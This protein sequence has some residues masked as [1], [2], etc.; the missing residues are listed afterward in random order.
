VLLCT[1][2]REGFPN[3]FIEARSHGVL[4]VSTHDHDGTIARLGWGQW[5]P[6]A[7]RLAPALQAILD[8]WEAWTP[9]PPQRRYKHYLRNHT[10]DLVTE[11]FE[12]ELVGRK[13]RGIDWHLRRTSNILQMSS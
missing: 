3:T 1:S 10:V 11:R 2:D 9:A 12:A 8:S 13:E 7:S 4:V 5:P 6:V